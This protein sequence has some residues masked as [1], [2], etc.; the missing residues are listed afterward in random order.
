M[1]PVGDA[2]TAMTSGSY[3]FCGDDSDVA[4]VGIEGVNVIIYC[5]VPSLSSG[6]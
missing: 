4:G 2:I 5:T 1:D 3:S 6:H